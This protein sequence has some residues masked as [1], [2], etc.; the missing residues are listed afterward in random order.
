MSRYVVSERKQHICCSTWWE[1]VKLIVSKS[2][3]NLSGI[4]HSILVKHPERVIGHPQLGKQFCSQHGQVSNGDVDGVNHLILHIVDHPQSP[5]QDWLLERKQ[6]YLPQPLSFHCLPSQNYVLEVKV[7][8]LFK[9]VVLEVL[10]W[11]LLGL[12]LCLTLRSWTQRCV[13]RLYA[14]MLLG[15]L[16]WMNTQAHHLCLTMESGVLRPGRGKGMDVKQRG[17]SRVRW[18]NDGDVIKVY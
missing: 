16:L 1:R 12:T 5:R 18:S 11:E 2:D 7:S 3:E 17:T 14:G 6:L 4:G 10:T 8:K 13:I 15:F 9:P